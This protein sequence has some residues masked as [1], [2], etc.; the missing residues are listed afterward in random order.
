LLTA[1]AATN[2]LNITGI[3]CDSRRVEPGYLFAA[4]PG[5]Q[6]D[7]RHF[8]PDAIGRGAA[9]I[10]A[11]AGTQPDPA[12]PGVAMITDPDPR[13]LYAL[14]AANFYARQPATV[15]AVTGTSGKTSTAHFLRQIW[16]RLG[17]KAGAMG[18]L[19][20]VATGPEGDQLLPADDKALTTPD[21]A[22]LHRQLR[23]LADAGV[24]HLAM[25]ASSHGLDQRRLD[26]VRIAAAAFTNLSHDHLDYHVTESAYLD[27]KVRLFRELLV[28]GGT[29]V[30]NGDQLYADAVIAACRGRGLPLIRYGRSGDRVRLA[31]LEPRADGQAMTVEV[32]GRAY[33]VTLSLVGDFQASNALCA[34]SL[35]LATGAGPDAAIAALAGLTGA[36]GRMQWIANTAKG[37]AVY[38]DYAHKPDALDRALAALRPHA[39]G[40]LGVVFGCG[41]DRDAAKRPEMG[42]I[43]N[44]RADWTIVTDDNP[45]SEDPAEI[46][47]AILA[48]A[49]DAR[50][51][52]DRRDAIAAGIEALEAGDLLVVA[53]KGHETG[54]IVGD[55]VLP[56]NDADVIRDLIGAGA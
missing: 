15:A 48:A 10:L 19:G 3:T 18:T 56:F 32:D 46:R 44:K 41:G 39:E 26:G 9:A 12:H 8:I 17:L 4:M 16:N 47:R 27:A 31:S 37:G 22:D 49:T 36:P 51:I 13:R 33:D 54:Q 42:V 23:E 21:A 14:M 45:R 1:A 20:V 53:G 35:A 11:P 52:G 38:V 29:A 5:T 40:R 28:D 24:D 55:E 7:G 34:L 25:E 2:E 30:V 43:A 6:I 50:E